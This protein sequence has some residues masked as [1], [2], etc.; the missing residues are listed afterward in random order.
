[1]LKSLATIATLLLLVGCSRF[2]EAKEREGCQKVH[3]NDQVAA[4]KCFKTATDKWA[5][6]YAWLPRV[7]ERQHQTP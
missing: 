7:I 6:A 2:E 1:M 5:K 4:D 3:P